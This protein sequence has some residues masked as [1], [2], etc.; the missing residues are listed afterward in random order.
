MKFSPAI[1]LPYT[2]IL[3][4]YFYFLTYDMLLNP[5][6]K[7][8][9]DILFFILVS[10]HLG[11][12]I[13]EKEKNHYHGNLNIAVSTMISFFSFVLRNFL[14]IP[15]RAGIAQEGG[16]IPKIRDFLLIIIIISALYSLIYQILTTLSKESIGAQSRLKENKRSLLQ[17]TTY[18]FLI[19]FPIIILINFVATAKNYN[20]DLSSIGKFSYSDISRSIIKQVDK[21]ITVTAF[22]P[23]P[24]EASG[25][26]ES[27]ILSAV[28]MELSI[29]LEQL[30]AINPRIEVRF[31]NADVEKE[32]LGEFD[33]ISN[34]MIVL[35]TLKTGSSPGGSPY[36]EEKILVQSKK[37]LE[38]LERKIVQALNNLT[39]PSKNI[40]FTSSNGEHYGENYSK[41]PDGKINKLIDNL[42]FFNYQVK[43]LGF[44]EGWSPVLPDDADLIAIIGPEQ[45]FSEEAKNALL[46]YVLQKKGKLLITIDPKSKENFQWLLQKTALDFEKG[47]LRQVQGRPEIIANNFPEHPISSLFLKKELGSVY[48]GSGYFEKRNS[49]TEI[50]FKEEIFLESG[51]STFLDLNN[52]DKMDADEKQNNFILGSVLIANSPEE[53]SPG[54]DVAPSEK[55][56]IIIFSGTEWITDRY[57]IYN[58]NPILAGNSFNYLNQKQILNSILPKKEESPLITLTQNQKVF[59][60]SIGLFGYPFSV[61]L[62]LSMYVI[63]RRNQK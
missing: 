15:P 4:L 36:L 17:N 14:D 28:R 49:R 2:S 22:Y 61:I 1:V 53:N 12:I 37:D 51:F 52:N 6:L 27:W 35:R 54:A 9:R 63:S 13:V 62:G 25:K 42:T 47:T 26:E 29:Y 21:K 8:A 5:G 32:L 16:K 56:K 41:I 24:L 39:T 44:K 43:E 31:I 7:V 3:S 60:W 18:N 58:L 11:Y 19:I 46:N 40:Y 57:Y 59:I 30:S 50:L 34:G 38:E 23:R 45:E 33:Q 55:G 48:P 10:L 20:F